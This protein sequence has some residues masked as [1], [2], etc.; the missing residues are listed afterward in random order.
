MRR[1]A[2]AI[3]AL[4]LTACAPAS[5]IAQAPTQWSALRIES[6]PVRSRASRFGALRFRGGLELS[7]RGPRDVFGG[8]S[9]L[10]ALEGDRILAVSD[11]GQWLE[12]RLVFNA[13]GD[14]VGLRDTRAA[15]L[16]D[17]GGAVFARKEAADA[18][19]LAQLPDGRF[20]VS[21]EQTQSVRIYDMNRDGPFG[22]ARPGPRLL[23][24]GGLPLNSGLEALAAT[25]EGALLIGAEGGDSA[26]TPLWLA[27]LDG[28]DVPEVAR[29][30]LERGY[31]LT[32]LDRLPSGDFI[33]L[34]RFFAPVIGAR[35]R[36]TRFS[37]SALEA[38]G[39]IALEELAHLAPP[40]PVDNFEALTV[41]RTPDGG[42]R[43]YI[44]SDDN[45]SARQR[46]LLLAFDVSE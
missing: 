35:A 37:P 7:L 25:A 3:S 4:V 10:E 34:E 45:F 9:G 27:P 2:A 46:T 12:A 40:M 16:R 22:P 42:V 33:A 24:V 29:Y 6:T 43:I 31:S 5:S 28:V 36:I 44:L 14:L 39:V 30:P 23:G 17:E 38:G 26:S 11:T 1:F 21:F 8:F 18:E 19:D 15:P 20:A 13:A 32:S 41:A